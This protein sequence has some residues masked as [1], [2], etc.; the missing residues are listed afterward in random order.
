MIGLPPMAV[1]V[2]AVMTGGF[3]FVPVF[4]AVMVAGIVL[5]FPFLSWFNHKGALKL[6][7]EIPKSPAD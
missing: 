3:K 5:Y 4:L 2:T 1:L 6:N 7:D